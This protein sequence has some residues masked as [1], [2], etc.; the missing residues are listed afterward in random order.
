MNGATVLSQPAI[1]WVTDLNWKIAGVGDFD[2][3]GKSDILWRNGATGQ[4]L[5]WL[6]NGST[7]VGQPVINWVTDFNWSIAGVGDFDGDGKS[8]ILWHNSATGS[9]TIWR[10][11]GATISG[12][13]VGFEVVADLNWNITGVGDFDGDGKSDIQWRNSATGENM[14]WFMSGAT[15]LSR[16]LLNTVADL[17]WQPA[18]RR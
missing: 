13:A 3:D 10:M 4:N 14:A 18:A 11:S 9:N 17:N 1:N 7:I 2:G 15:I 8:D 16:P 12:G 6:M 5:V